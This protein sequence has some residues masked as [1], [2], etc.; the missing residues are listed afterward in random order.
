M[1]S[2]P[3]DCSAPESEPV[4]VGPALFNLPANQTNQI[5][6]QTNPDN[7]NDIF[8]NNAMLVL[9]V[10]ILG[11]PGPR[12]SISVHIPQ[13]CILPDIEFHLFRYFSFSCHM[14]QVPEKLQTTYFR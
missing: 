7:N 1:L 4:N 11:D 6:Q 8:N 3:K 13:I 12:M 10:R 9:F 2:Q 5:D 14:I